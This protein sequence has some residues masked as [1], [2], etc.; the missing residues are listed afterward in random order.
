MSEQSNPLEEALLEL[1]T[2]AASGVLEVAEDPKRW[3]FFLDSGDLVGTRSNLKSETEDQLRKELPNLTEPELLQ[4]QAGRRLA[5]ACRA[6]AT[7]SFK[8][9]VAPSRR[10]NLHV[11]RALFEAVRASR[12][13]EALQA[14]LAP[15][16][17]GWPVSLDPEAEITATSLDA[18]L[19]ALDGSRPGEDI[20]TFAPAEPAT[21]LA[22]VWLGWRLG[23]VGDQG[24]EA[25]PTSMITASAE[26]YTPTPPAPAPAPASPPTPAPR[27]APPPEPDLSGAHV[28]ELPSRGPATPPPLPS[29][30]PAEA[31][32]HARLMELRTLISE[33]PNHFVALGMTWQASPTELRAAYMRL[34]RDLHPDRYSGAPPE[35]ADLATELFDRVR[36]A[37]EELGDEAKRL[38]YI[39]RVIHGKKSEDELAMEA[40]QRYLSAET[41]F[42]RGMAAFNAGQISASLAHFQS[43]AEGAPDETEFCGYYGYVLFTTRLRTEPERA[44]EGF[45]ILEQA[46]ADNKGQ[47][48][49]RDS[50]HV[51][52]GRAWRE[53][54]DPHLARKAAVAALKIN[55]NNADAARLI[56]RLQDEEAAAAQKAESGVLG[57]VQGM[58]GGLFKKRS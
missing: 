5:N 36:A 55:A 21:T 13:A 20:V 29:A 26:A 33:A 38:S 22:A 1:V 12:D 58:F 16:L 3:Q 24:G 25:S 10:V 42:K 43:A 37:W 39:D 14:R 30:A 47:E 17:E 9:G 54:G 57:R 41:D 18:Y 11:R 51:L 32:P 19:A 50:L 56:R 35:V 27:P 44:I 48:R 8:R 49:Q 34:A 45:R 40:V 46:I 15:L 52:L 4:E 6:N 7:W 2:T 53:R 31:G 28:A 23:A